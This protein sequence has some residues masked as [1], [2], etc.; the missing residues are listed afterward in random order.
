MQL[1]SI[2]KCSFLCINT[3]FAIHFYINSEKA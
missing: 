1:F 3:I 2:G